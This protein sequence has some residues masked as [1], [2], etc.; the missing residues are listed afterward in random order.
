MGFDDFFKQATGIGEGPFPFQR[1][2][3]AAQALPNL[4][5]V[6]TGLGKTAMV[7]LGWIWRRFHAEPDIGNRTPRRLIYCLPTRALVEQVT[8][9][10]RT[11]VRRLRLSARLDV[12][13]VVGGEGAEDWDLYPEQTAILIGTQDMLLSRA[14]NRGYG[15]SRYRWPMP[16]ALLNND[17]LWVFDEVQLM[18]VGAATSAQ[19]E[20]FRRDMKAFG[21]TQ[22]IWMS[23]TLKESCL[24]TVDYSTDQLG[25][26]LELEDEDHR[27]PLVRKLRTAPK[28]LHHSHAPMGEA[29]ACAQ[30]VAQAHRAGTRTLAVFNTAERASE[31]YRQ[32][33][34]LSDIPQPVLIHSSFRPDDRHSRLEVLL[35]GDDVIA[36]TT[37]AVEAGVDLSATTLLTELAPW[38]SLV[39]RFGRC[40]RSGDEEHPAVIWFDPGE[41]DDQFEEASPY[42]AADLKQARRLLRS[43]QS[44]SLQALAPIAA[45]MRLEGAPLIRRRDLVDLFDTTPDLA[46]NDIDVSCFI[47]SGGEHDLQ[48][49]WRDFEEDPVETAPRREELCS[50]PVGQ[51]REFYRKKRGHVWRW[52]GLEEQWRGVVEREIYPGQTFLVRAR[53]GGYDSMVGWNPR[54]G[55]VDPLPGSQEQPEGYGRDCEAASWTSIAEHSDQVVAELNPIVGNVPIDASARESL[56]EAARGH[57]WGKG[58]GIFQAAVESEGRPPG[59][60]GRLDVG[61]APGGFWKD[62]ERP[63]FRYELASALAMLEAGQSDLSVYLAAAHHGKVRLSIRSWPNETHPPEPGRLHARGVWD[64]DEIPVIDLGGAVLA[65]WTRLSLDCMQMGRSP[66]GSPSWAERMLRLR[67]GWGAFRLAYLEALL[68]AADMRAGKR[69]AER[70]K[71]PR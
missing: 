50:V 13:L 14:L 7:V 67:D 59:W 2:F 25:S 57:D 6:P 32:L 31:T 23:A 36:V 58:H 60:R 71:E 47:R 46:G 12:H 45:E 65:P 1:R 52:D 15:M 51:F 3:A 61:K 42:G 8:A 20:A 34:K 48:V 4:V 29:A 55:P 35:K 17:C 38:A 9:S 43:C 49:F 21:T 41:I 5:R 10:A 37:P 56:E 44:V 30:A 16:F 18:D 27:N 68:R 66:K 53:A 11:W 22:S 28:P 63:G 70:R 64:S 26:P 39:Q 54:S 69:E 62:Y 40:N 24:R 33:C 19:L